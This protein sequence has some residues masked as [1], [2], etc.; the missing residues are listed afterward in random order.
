MQGW[1]SLRQLIEE[2]EYVYLESHTRLFGE[3]S[4]RRGG[5][6]FEEEYDSRYGFL[7]DLGYIY[8]NDTIITDLIIKNENRTWARYIPRI[9]KA[10][11][12]VL[13]HSRK[14]KLNPD[15]WETITEIAKRVK[16]KLP[17]IKIVPD[18]ED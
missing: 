13:S 5:W 8:V 12:A 1:S 18:G 7:Y 15:E 10:V 4:V 17:L 16:E 2:N 9:E 14:I 11:K 6:M 3:N